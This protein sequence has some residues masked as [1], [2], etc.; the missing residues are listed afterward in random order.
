MVRLDSGN[1]ALENYAL[2]QAEGVEW[3]ERTFKTEGREVL[4]KFRMVVEV[5]ERTIDKHGKALLLPLTDV[6]AWVTSLDLPEEE[7]VALYR[8][9][10][11]SE[12]F[13]SELKGE[14]D[15][16]RLPSGKFAT[17]TLILELGTLANNVLRLMGQIGL[18]GF[19]QRAESKRRRIRA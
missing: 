14:L 4:V 18:K 19:K 2:F 8:D 12:Q 7:V 9:H 11:T 1:D 10:G 13:H 3:Q 6:V 16:E 15:L 17:N 5:V